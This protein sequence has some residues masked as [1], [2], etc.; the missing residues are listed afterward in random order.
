MVVPTLSAIESAVSA[1]KGGGWVRCGFARNGDGGQ[2][3]RRGERQT[4]QAGGRSRLKEKCGSGRG[5]FGDEDGQCG[6]G[7]RSLREQ[8]AN[9]RGQWREREPLKVLSE[10]MD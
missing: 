7:E 8:R 2:R 9:G 6:Q 3:S 10:R 5:R 1:E 4:F